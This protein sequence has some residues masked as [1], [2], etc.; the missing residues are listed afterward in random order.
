[1][2]SL[3]KDQVA[4]KIQDAINAIGPSVQEEEVDLGN[5][6][7]ALLFLRLP[8][9]TMDKLRLHAINAEGKFDKALHVGASAR[10]VAASLCDNTGQPV[11]TLEQV[12]ALPTPIVDALN[13]AA[14]KANG[15]TTEAKAD[16]A[17]KSEEIPAA[18]SS[19]S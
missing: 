13:L 1:M 7:T 11:M 9:I 3:N 10:L 18:N 2:E 15:L 6:K 19:S 14:Q 8:F 17:K 12:M 4:K 16:I 5:G